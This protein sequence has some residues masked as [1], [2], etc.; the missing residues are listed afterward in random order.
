VSF[1]RAAL[2]LTAFAAVLALA[3]TAAAT[4]IPQQGIA[5]AELRMS[6]PEV[7]DV[8]GDPNRVKHGNNDFGPY[9][10]FQYHR[11]AVTFQGNE[12]A[13]AIT[14][15]RWKEKTPQGIGRGSTEEELK[16]AH[17]RAKCRTEEGTFRHCWLGRFQP[18]RRVTDF[19]IRSGK[20]SRV[21]VAFVID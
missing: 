17:P 10:V 4:I 8:L 5:G 18:G 3:G 14:T 11:L 6:R 7:R 13:T 16:D 20:V 12:E 15:R 2:V 21:T 1:S 9:T 19:R